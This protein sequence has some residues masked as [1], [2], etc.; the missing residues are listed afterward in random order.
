MLT[1]SSDLVDANKSEAENLQQLMMQLQNAQN[2]NGTS[3]MFD[4]LFNQALFQNGRSSAQT[5]HAEQSPVF[6]EPTTPAINSNDLMSRLLNDHPPQPQQ[7]AQNELDPQQLLNFLATL[8]PAEGGADL[9]RLLG[10]NATSLLGPL[11]TQTMN[12]PQK[13]SNVSTTASPAPQHS[14]D[15]PVAKMPRLTAQTEKKDSDLLEKLDLGNFLLQQAQ[16]QIR[17]PTNSPENTPPTPHVNVPTSSDP[18]SVLNQLLPSL[19]MPNF[20]FPMFPNFNSQSLGLENQL[21]M[22]RMAQLVNQAQQVPK[23]PK[24]QYSSTSKNYCDLCNKEVCNKYFLRT[25]MLKMHNIVIDENKSV[26]ANIDTL[27]K[28]KE[29][30]LSFRCD[31]C[32]I[33]LDTRTQLRD[34]KRDAHG[35]MPLTNAQPVPS[36]NNNNHAGSSASSECEVSQKTPTN[37]DSTQEFTKLEPQ[38]TVPPPS[39]SSS[40]ASISE[41]C[42]PVCVGKMEAEKLSLHLMTHHSNQLSQTFLDGMKAEDQV[43]ESVDEAALRFARG[44][45]EFRPGNKEEKHSHTSGSASPLSVNIPEAYFQNLETSKTMHNQTVVLKVLDQNAN[46]PEELLAY[47]PVKTQITQPIRLTIELRPTPDPKEV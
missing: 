7:P 8:N 29:G 37:F 35:I 23:T 5:E 34:H 13:R 43:L 31:L 44:R 10:P 24:R 21:D 6:S 41:E 32:K 17:S 26:I 25:H 11:D 47:L 46:L 2:S 42:C 14:D 16:K 45:E 19:S 1:D 15:R 18:A 27:E 36:T 22:A 3:S 12:K 40:T 28:E 4:T 33:K 38:D 39:S 9:M 30:G 20:N